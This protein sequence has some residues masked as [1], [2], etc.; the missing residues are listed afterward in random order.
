[1]ALRLVGEVTLDGAGFERGLTRL[2]TSAA[3]NLKSFVV[4]A[5]GIYGIE[6]AIKKT[7]DRCSE[8]VNASQKLGVTVEQLQV[9]REA[10]KQGGV[11]F[12]KL[13][14][15]ANKLAAIRGN[16]LGG[17]KGAA[18][19]MKA[20]MNLGITPEMVGKMTGGELMMGPIAAKIKE[21]NPADIANDLKVVFGRAFGDLLPVLQTDFSALQTKMEGLGIIIDTKTAVSLKL[22][23][24]EFSL[25]G[26]IIV[27]FL[28]P[29]LVTLGEVLFWLIGQIKESYAYLKNLISP[30]KQGAPLTKEGGLSLM[31][32]RA[33]GGEAVASMYGRWL[34]QGGNAA[35]A[36]SGIAAKNEKEAETFYQHIAD[37]TYKI[38]HPTPADLSKTVSTLDKMHPWHSASDALLSTGN[39]LGSGRGAIGSVAQQHLE[40]A[41]ESLT[42]LQE[43]ND[44]LDK[45]TDDDSSDMDFGS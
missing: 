30:D 26:G 6:Q 34:Q 4:G 16:I 41:K 2:G 38:T 35:D 25:L 12:G 23:E 43:M 7:V 37:V 31:I 5:F 10:A 24:D 36:A 39:F 14:T 22:M 13:V 19:Q 32:M 11:E 44:K 28:A 33:L 17:G 9:M 15:A 45:L 20:L 42:Q 29:K 40:V 18:D 8:L 1:M 3:N 27:S 21:V